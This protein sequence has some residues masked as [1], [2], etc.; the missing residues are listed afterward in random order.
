[1]PQPLTRS[2]S[3][4]GPD[5]RMW[6]LY[7]LSALMLRAVTGTA[8]I[9]SSARLAASASPRLAIGSSSLVRAT[10]DGG[11]G[12][13]VRPRAFDPTYEARPG[14][15]SAAGHERC[16]PAE[17]DAGLCGPC[18]ASQAGRRGA[19]KG[20]TARL[21]V[22]GQR[23]GTRRSGTDPRK[24]PAPWLDDRSATAPIGHPGRST[25][26]PDRPGA[27]SAER[28]RRIDPRMTS[29]TVDEPENEPPIE[30]SDGQ[31]Y[32]G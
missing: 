22:A 21:S 17:F 29:T 1:M 9:T 26:T 5:A 24:E 12:T 32:G 20:A 28:R 16:V 2:P 15:V 11:T 4:V 14:P 19:R 7:R 10:G 31:V 3:G 25:R 27:A 13:S 8:A 6:T 23:A 18:K 30:R